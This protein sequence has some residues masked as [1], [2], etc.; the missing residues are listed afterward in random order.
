MHNEDEDIEDG[1]QISDDENADNLEE[2]ND[3]GLDEEDPDKDR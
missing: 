1:F 2:I 3:F